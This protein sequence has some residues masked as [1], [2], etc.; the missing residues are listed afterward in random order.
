MILVKIIDAE[1]FE[2]SYLY[3][4]YYWSFY[5]CKC[6]NHSMNAED[7]E[8]CK[9]CNNSDSDRYT[10]S[11]DADDEKE[12]LLVNSLE[13]DNEVAYITLDGEKYELDSDCFTIIDDNNA[14]LKREQDKRAVNNSRI[15]RVE[16]LKK[17]I[18]ELKKII[19][20][21]K[22][23]N[24]IIINNYFTKKDDKKEF[25]EADGYFFN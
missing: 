6:D 2:K 4:N 19:R 20:D 22:E 12:T 16:E 14:D 17:E 10:V 11:W 13:I 1:L 21:S 18:S 25:R 3:S 7:Q 9:F 15:K 24:P 23:D 5:C 8:E